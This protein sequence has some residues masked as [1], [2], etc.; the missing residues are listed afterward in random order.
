MTAGLA[1]LGVYVLP[2]DDPLAPA[3]ARKQFD[4]LG[5]LLLVAA[6][7]QFNFAWNQA[8]L[9]GWSAPYDLDTLARLG[10]RVCGT[11]LLGEENGKTCPNPYRSP[12]QS[13]SLDVPESL[14]WMAKLWHLPV[15]YNDFASCLMH[16][17][18]RR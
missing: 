2:P 12:L 6:L 5:T 9:V 11:F 13:Q 18:K 7:G 14:A 3:S 10:D 1:L 15:L 17:A 4:Y 16:M 8:P